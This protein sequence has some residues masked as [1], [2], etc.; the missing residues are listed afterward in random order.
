MEMEAQGRR[1]DGGTRMKLHGGEE[2]MQEQEENKRKLWRYRDGGTGQERESQMYREEE[3]EM[4][5]QVKEKQEME[6]TAREKVIGVQ[7]R[8]EDIE[9]RDNREKVKQKKVGIWTGY[10]ENKDIKISHRSMHKSKVGN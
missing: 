9:V 1:G 6:A 5:T 8:G 10:Q 4:E 2:V 7:K 3:D